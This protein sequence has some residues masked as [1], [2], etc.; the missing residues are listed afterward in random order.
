MKIHL[1]SGR[2][3]ANNRV[4][5]KMTEA[6]EGERLSKKNRAFFCLE[7]KKARYIMVRAY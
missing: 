1:I 2:I 6:F 7:T 5:E 4:L 3:A